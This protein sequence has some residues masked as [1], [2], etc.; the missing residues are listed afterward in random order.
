MDYSS[1][2]INIYYISK[3]VNKS[4]GEKSNFVQVS[5]KYSLSTP[6]MYTTQRKINALALPL[7]PG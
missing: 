6:Q 2:S 5:I 7:K 1:C 3:W 4:R